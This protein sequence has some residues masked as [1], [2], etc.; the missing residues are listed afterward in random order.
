M[1]TGSEWF[2]YVVTTLVGLLV[3]VV[4]GVWKSFAGDIKELRDKLDDR[5]GTS[6]HATD[7][8]DDQIWDELKAIREV[9]A[10]HAR[11]DA[12]VHMKFA[13]EIASLAS[14]EDLNRA[15]DLQTDK[16]RAIIV[17]LKDKP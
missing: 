11:D 6:E 17:N 1:E 4:G 15:L 9:I 14:R 16:L 3:V 2:K 8:N 12:A 10:Q 7:R 13:T 5:I